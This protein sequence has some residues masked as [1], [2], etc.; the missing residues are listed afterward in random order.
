ML[1]YILAL[2]NYL[3]GQTARGGAYGYKLDSLLK[4]SDIKMKDNK[5]TLFMYVIELVE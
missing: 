4:L 2:G 3:N 1:E 5:T